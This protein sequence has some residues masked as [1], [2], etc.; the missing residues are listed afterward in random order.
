MHTLCSVF[1]D[2]TCSLM[3]PQAWPLS[4]RMMHPGGGGR[5]RGS[6]DATTPAPLP[7]SPKGPLGNLCSKV[8]PSGN[9]GRQRCPAL[10]GGGY[11]KIGA[12]GSVAE[13]P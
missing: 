12:H 2:I 7:P 8:P 9:H 1:T 11:K 10:Y 3:P 5:F 4:E 13:L 6:S